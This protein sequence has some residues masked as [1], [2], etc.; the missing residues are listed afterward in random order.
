MT[1]VINLNR[2]KKLKFKGSSIKKNKTRI[3]NIMDEK[4]KILITIISVIS[5][6]SGCII[7]KYYLSEELNAICEN[8][9]TI[10][11]TGSFIEIFL[12]LIKIEVLFYI[13]IF[14]IG[15]TM[16][17]T[18]I[19][20]FPIIIKCIIIGYFSSYIYATYEIKGI[21]FC[22]VLLYPYLAITT[23]THII[24]TNESIYMSKYVLNLVLNKKTADDISLRLY[25]IRYFILVMINLICVIVNSF[26]IKMLGT[27]IILQI[28]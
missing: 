20:M 18:P 14:S 28:V 12:T 23:T 22:L 16:L 21:L 11:Q 7:Y 13:I 27:K 2:R 9:L 1:K 4:Y 3:N 25:L 24:A 17:G 8:L 6:L 26:I 15:T 19:V 10:I 5:I